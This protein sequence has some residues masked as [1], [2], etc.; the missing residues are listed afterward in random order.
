[1]GCGAGACPSMDPLHGWPSYGLVGR[2]SW[3]LSV[4][5]RLSNTGQISY[6]LWVSFIHL[7]ARQIKMCLAFLMEVL[8]ESIET[9][10]EER[11]CKQESILHQRGVLV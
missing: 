2:A 10:L 1:M 3:V 7:K 11:L 9:I 4:S 6:L 8:R 5:C